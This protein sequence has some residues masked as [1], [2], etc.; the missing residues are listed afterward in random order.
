[1]IPAP[2]MSETNEQVLSTVAQMLREVVGDEF[3]DVG[4]EMETSFSEDL[5]LESIEF[6]ALAERMQQRY[7]QAVDFAGWLSEMELDRI[8]ALSVGDVVEFIV[9]CRS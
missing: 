5:E 7:G 4:I 6:V 9:R 1:M 8:L 2:H 3:L